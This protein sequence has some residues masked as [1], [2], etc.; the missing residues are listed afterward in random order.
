MIGI[1]AIAEFLPEAFVDNVDQARRFGHD[2]EFLIKHI[3]SVRLPVMPASMETSD[4][5]L[6]AVTQLAAKSALCVKDIS[7]LVVVT[8]NGDGDGLPHTA[9]IV[10]EKLGISGD[11]AAFDISL[12]CSGYV[13]GLSIVRALM[14]L[15]GMNDA[16]LVTADPYSKIVSRRDRVTSLLFG[17]AATATWLS[18]G[19]EW[20]ISQA[21]LG[22]DGRGADALFS[23]DGTLTMNGR[24][25]Y[26]FA[27]KAVPAQIRRWLESQHLRAEDIDLYCLHQGSAAVVAAI[28]EQFPTVRE[29]FVSEMSETGNTVS[30]SIPIL[31]KRHVLSKSI[32][33]V[34]L[35][36]FG[37]GFSFGTVMIYRGNKHDSGTHPGAP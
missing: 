11:V 35:S 17:D 4:L 6:H 22:T 28:A 27:V 12:G 24:K 1:N 9:A 37:V 34:L 7:A 18:R 19:G 21:T 31:L 30:S 14:E 5:A 25:V 33:R 16:V 10:L 26:N 36:G 23:R 13:Y 3:G 8:Q 20:K 15:E 2:S 32:S 29:R